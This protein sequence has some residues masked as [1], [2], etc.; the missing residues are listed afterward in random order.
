[1]VLDDTLAGP[2]TL[3]LL[4]YLIYLLVRPEQF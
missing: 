4:A 1:M 2:V 3:R